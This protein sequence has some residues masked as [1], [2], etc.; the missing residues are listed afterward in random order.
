[1]RV[2]SVCYLPTRFA[3][4]GIMFKKNVNINIKPSGHV[5][6]Q[7]WKEHPGQQ[8]VHPKQ[9]NKTWL[10]ELFFENLQSKMQNLISDVNRP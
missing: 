8:A 1:M 2:C 4:R 9:S 6:S 3:H 10:D 5:K 7:S